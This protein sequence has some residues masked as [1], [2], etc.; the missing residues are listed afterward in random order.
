MSRSF[1]TLDSKLVHPGIGKG[2]HG[3]VVRQRTAHADPLWIRSAGRLWCQGQVGHQPAV[4]FHD[5]AVL[6]KPERYE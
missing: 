1:K 2:P 4:P 6:R 3:S 5:V